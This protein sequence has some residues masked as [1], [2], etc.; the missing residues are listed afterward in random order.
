MLEGKVNKRLNLVP[1]EGTE[2][3]A[4]QVD[5]ENLWE[6]PE[7]KFLQG[8]S[9]FLALRAEPRVFLG[10]PLLLEEEL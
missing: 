6:S 2:G 9:V 7:V 8:L 10:Q 4:L 1:E 5:D 3:K